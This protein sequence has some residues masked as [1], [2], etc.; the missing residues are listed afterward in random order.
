MPHVPPKETAR[1]RVEQ[2]KR[3]INRHRYRYHVLDAPD[4]SD[5]AFDSLKH[6]L[7]QLETAY[8]ELATPDS[9]TQRVGGE[10]LDAFNKIP[11]ESPMLSIEDI[12]SQEELVSWEDFLKRRSGREH[13][14]Y[15]CE[16][17]ID[18]IAI[19]LVYERGVLV[20]GVTRGDGRIG[21]DVTANIKTISA[22]PLRLEWHEQVADP[23]VTRQANEV[24][25]AG[26]L[27]IRGEA[28]T[29]LE[30]FAK[31]NQER[32]R[33]RED[34]FANPRNLTAGSIRQLDPKLAASRPL[35]FI[36]YSVASNVGQKA[37]A[38]EHELMRAL[39]IPIDPTAGVCRDLDDVMRYWHEIE[40]KR[41]RL[42]YQIDGVVVSVNDE[43]LFEELGVAGKSPRAIRAFKFSPKQSTTVV[44]DIKV[45]VGRTGAITP[46]ALLRPVELSGVTVS[47]A[48]LHNQDE[49]DRLDV[50]IGDTVVV[51]RAGD[52]IP[53]VVGVVDELRPKK[54]KPYLLPK[55]CPECTTPLVRPK[56]EAITR[57]PNPACESRKRQ[58]LRYF[59]SKSAFDV[60]GMGPQI[61]NQLLDS[62]L[63][64]D[65]A[66][67]FTL[68]KGDVEQLERFGE[69][70]AQ[71]LID[72]IEKSKRISLARFI[73]ALN[74]RHVGEETA[75][76]L[77]REFGTIE[78]LQRA[79][80]EELRAVDGI[81]AVVARE[82]HQWFSRKEHRALVA[83]LLRA[84]VEIEPPATTGDK[85]AGTTFVFTGSMERYT[86]EEAEDIVRSLG[87][88]VASS[89]SRATDYVVVG[90]HPGSK[91]ETA[92]A[93]G[94]TVL[95]ETAFLKLIKQ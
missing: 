1:K 95:D 40:K 43:E 66:D 6:E 49:I 51:E 94:V 58:Y 46:I 36:G 23:E 34:P 76:D 3:A 44:E 83:Q 67:I 82:I 29:P 56:G 84:G 79:S 72:A 52:V 15:F 62:E 65:P 41:N 12:F 54:A 48:T 78:A 75:I 33:A 32:M 57:C 38:Q 31:L 4:I 21:E 13:P 90:E 20:Q 71:N 70:S 11:H 60:D 55:T 93:L 14:E 37:H 77:A 8:P 18:G 47:R 5:A 74:I 53:D 80:L 17:K 22:V 19:A 64:S 61:I 9:P 26:R 10:A 88:K 24:L 28:Y 63:I 30:A 69:K 73:N 35:S 2:L 86:R 50:R 91:Y 45:Q 87:A 7:L 27:E 92:K 39:G 81:G 89:V 68:R 25:A 85:L 59:V 16:L 42:P